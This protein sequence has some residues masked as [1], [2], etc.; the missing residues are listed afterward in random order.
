MTRELI[1]ALFGLFIIFMVGVLMAAT[2]GGIMG[3]IAVAAY[4]VFKLLT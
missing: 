2:A 4:Y 1:L 3:T